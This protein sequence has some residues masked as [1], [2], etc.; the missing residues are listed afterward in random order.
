[1]KTLTFILMLL[2][3]SVCFSQQDTA[4]ADCKPCRKHP[5]VIGPAFKIRGVLSFWNGSPS[6]RIWKVGTK[7]ILGVSEQRFYKEDYC[8]LPKW[9][10]TIGIDEEITGDFVLYPFTKDKPGEMRLVCIDT[11]YNVKVRKRK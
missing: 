5:G 9:L 7:R 2:S 1:M 10:P 8:N 4:N 6:V 11:I 3:Y